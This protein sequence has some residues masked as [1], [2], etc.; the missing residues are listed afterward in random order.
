MANA[1]P[2]FGDLGKAARDIFD[3]GYGMLCL[4]F[5]PRDINEQLLITMC[6]CI[7]F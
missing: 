3:K 2:L 7:L 6:N 1:P 5:C 4:F